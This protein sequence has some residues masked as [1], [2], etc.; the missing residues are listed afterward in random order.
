M[1]VGPNMSPLASAQRYLSQ[2]VVCCQRSLGLPHG[3]VAV[4]LARRGGGGEDEEAGD[5][6]VEEE[7]VV[8]DDDR[9]SGK[10]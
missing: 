8:T 9:P 2:C 10:V 3:P 7:A 4:E 1:Q 6:F 5:D